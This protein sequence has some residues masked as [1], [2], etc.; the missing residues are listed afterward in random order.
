[1]EALLHVLV[2]RRAEDLMTWRGEEGRRKE[3]QEEEGMIAR[4][5]NI[6]MKK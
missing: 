5:M 4:K 1:M 2:H 6:K 3:E